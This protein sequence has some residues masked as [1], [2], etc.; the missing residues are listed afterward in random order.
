MDGQKDR[1]GDK[2]HDLEKAREDQWAREQDRVLLGK[3]RARQH[4]ALYCPQCDAQLVPRPPG[5]SS[6]MACPDGHGA[7][8]DEAALLDLGSK[9]M[10]GAQL[11]PEARDPN[12][13]RQAKLECARTAAGSKITFGFRFRPCLAPFRGGTYQS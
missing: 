13:L 2:I 12:R 1:F 3:I 8:L 5:E 9:E 4:P 10:T 6:V 7:W 11:R